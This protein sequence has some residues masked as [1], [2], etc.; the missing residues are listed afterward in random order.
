MP[1]V[2]S[3]KLDDLNTT[4]KSY[5]SITNIFLNSKKIPTIPPLLFN[6]TLISV[7]KQKSGVFNLNFSS[8]CTPIN[9]SSKLPVF[10]YKTENYLDSVDIKEKDIYLVIK[11]LIPNKAHGW[12]DISIR[13]IKF[14]GK[15]FTFPLKLL[16]K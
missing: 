13:M 6:G 2:L 15:S 16:F 9:G 4:L 12:D 5:W 1:K 10:S 7:V 3:V 14:C 11:N 8:Q